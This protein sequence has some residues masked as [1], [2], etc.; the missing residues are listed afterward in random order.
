M[1]D[2]SGELGAFLRARRA[3]VKPE[4]VGLPHGQG[5]RRTPGLR[6]EEL[7]ALAGVS[8]D[9]LIR[10]EQGKET[11]PGTGILDALA[12]ALLLDS[13][14]HAHLY[15]LA[16]EAAHRTP[17]R[18]V[19]SPDPTAVRPSIEQLLDRLRPSPAYVLDPISD[20]A[21]PTRR[22]SPCSPASTS[23]RG[24]AGTLSATCSCTPPPTICSWTGKTSPPTHWRTCAPASPTRPPT[25][26]R[27]RL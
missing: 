19:G 16:N 26:P 1:A 22:P 11:N 6:R 4:A 3:R 10:L 17:P 18:G 12:G 5:I 9:Y 25:P 20:T 2:N 13:D 8:I 14:A 27:P 24:H 7:A 15:T 23:G 21:P